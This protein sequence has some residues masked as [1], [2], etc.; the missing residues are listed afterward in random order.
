MARSTFRSQNVQ[1]A[2]TTFWKLRCRKRTRC[3]AKHIS[4]SKCTKHTT[5]FRRFQRTILFIVIIVEKHEGKSKLGGS[6]SFSWSPLFNYTSLLSTVTNVQVHYKLAF[7]TSALPTYTGTL[8][9]SVGDHSDYAKALHPL[10]LSPLCFHYTCTTGH[11]TLH[12]TT[13]CYINPCQM[14]NCPLHV[15]TQKQITKSTLEVTGTSGHTTQMSTSAT[16]C[17]LQ[18]QRSQ[19][20][21]LHCR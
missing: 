17:R 10:S 6:A 14:S 7:L 18:A 19:K 4:K 8:A 21:Q 9:V 13:G 20:T 2:H 12:S 3:G 15:A 16:P 1:T 5:V 11:T